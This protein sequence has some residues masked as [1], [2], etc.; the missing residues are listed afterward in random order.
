MALEKNEQRAERNRTITLNKEEVNT[1][2]AKLC[3]I[4]DKENIMVDN[5]INKTIH[6][7]L[8]DIIDL[9]PKKFADL[10][11]IDPPYNLTKDFNGF[12]FKS[13]SNN[14]YLDYLRSWFGKVVELLKDN[15]SLYLCGDWKCT[16]SL[17]EVMNENMVVLNR[18]TWQ[19]EKGR[20]ALTNWKNG[21]EDIWFGVKNK[22]D[23]YFDVEAVKLKRKVLAPYKENGKPKDWEETPEGN[24]RLTYPSNFW[25]DI[26]IPY[27]SMPE[28]TDHPTQKPEKLIA[29]LILAS[30]PKNGI[31][32]DPF[33]GSGTTSVVAKKL[34]R[35][36]C[37]VEMNL[38]YA[39]LTEKRLVLAD[40]D[41]TIQGYSDGVF[42]ERNTANLQVKNNKKDKN[43]SFDLFTKVAVL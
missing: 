33:L 41:K 40:S 22:N 1:L 11:I 3:N 10:I 28:N 20:G 13:S 14:D 38:E 12:T 21:M 16:A 26:S 39:C 7:D 23:Y 27:W 25:D 37:G 34:E 2:T 36:Y 19:R 4:K 15:G 24:F 29:K 18:I 31:I 9:L 8:F 5:I 30:C 42:W 35:K 32:F 17:Q 6:N 43:N